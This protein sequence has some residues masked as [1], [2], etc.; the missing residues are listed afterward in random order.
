MK[1]IIY[2]CNNHLRSPPLSDA[3]AAGK[4]SCPSIKLF[5]Q[6]IGKTKS[7]QYCFQFSKM[8]LDSYIMVFSKLLWS[9]E[10]LFLGD[11]HG[12]EWLNCHAGRKKGSRIIGGALCDLLIF[13][14]HP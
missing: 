6:K 4:Y 3:T 11:R 9:A 2:E 8:P 10:R 7:V 12:H 13:F 14:P 5:Y 1:G